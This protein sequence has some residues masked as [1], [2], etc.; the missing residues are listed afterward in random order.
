MCS[1]K[2]LKE[3]PAGSIGMAQKGPLSLQCVHAHIYITLVPKSFRRKALGT[4]SMTLNLDF[5]GFR[6]SL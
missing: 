4:A 1:E 2:V 3:G 6:Q 5:A